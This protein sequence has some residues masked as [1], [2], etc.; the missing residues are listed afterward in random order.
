MRYLTVIVIA[1]FLSIFVAVEA[2]SQ[3][4]EDVVYLKNGSII[5]GLITELIPNEPVKIQTWDGNVFVY[6][7]DEILK[8]VK[9]SRRTTIIDP[10][11]DRL[12]IINPNQP[13][14]IF[15]EP[16]LKSPVLAT[17]LSFLVPGF[18]QFYLEQGARGGGYLAGWFIG[19]VL[20]VNGSGDRYGADLDPIGL[21]GTVMML[22]SWGSSMYDAY[23]DANRINQEY[24]QRLQGHLIQL[25]HIGI[26]PIVKQE[27]FGA[28]LTLRW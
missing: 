12:P 18:G 28:R 3:N 25:N 4:L 14:S 22:G 8:I 2:S 20:F 15:L 19:L 27:A 5:R 16:E 24:R 13:P 21:M 9:E 1:I 10:S 7:L 6:E 26:D 23:R 17:G 11:S